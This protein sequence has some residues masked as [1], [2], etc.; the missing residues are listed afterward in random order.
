MAEASWVS[1][2]GA[3]S[4]WAFYFV[5]GGLWSGVCDL[6]LSGLIVCKPTA[7]VFGVFANTLGVAAAG[8]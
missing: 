2:G 3:S 7:E 8:K 6:C 5:G 1:W 4:L